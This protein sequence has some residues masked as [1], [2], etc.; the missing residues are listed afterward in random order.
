MMT[1]PL[2]PLP[3]S[4]SELAALRSKRLNRSISASRTICS[5]FNWDEAAV[6]RARDYGALGLVGRLLSLGSS[7]SF[8]K[9][10]EEYRSPVKRNAPDYVR[11]GPPRHGPDL[12]GGGA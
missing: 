6:K 2:M 8:E 1:R 11:D 9:I 5:E 4:V 10:K 12:G 3:S 7:A